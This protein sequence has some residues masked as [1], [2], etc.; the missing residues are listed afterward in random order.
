VIATRSHA[1]AARKPGA[2]DESG[3]ERELS[4]GNAGIEHIDVVRIGRQ[5]A[6]SVFR[7]LTKLLDARLLQ[8]RRTVRLSDKAVVRVFT[9]FIA[10]MRYNSR[11]ERGK[12][13]IHGKGSF[14]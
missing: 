4:A 9:A 5:F 8:G 10:P 6:S 1:C 3:V 13:M 2:L 12:Q 14:G 7:L 11:T